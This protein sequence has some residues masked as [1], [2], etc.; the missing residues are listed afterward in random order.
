MNEYKTNYL[1]LHVFYDEKDDLFDK[2]FKRMMFVNLSAFSIFRRKNDW[3]N[4]LLIYFKKLD[5]NKQIRVQQ[6]DKI[7]IYSYKKRIDFINKDWNWK[8]IKFK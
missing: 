6:N 7:V 3:T 1:L 5:I 4:N 8:S 2:N